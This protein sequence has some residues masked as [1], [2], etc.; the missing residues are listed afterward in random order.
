MTVV[1]SSSPFSSFVLDSSR[2]RVTVSPAGSMERSTK[3]KSGSTFLERVL[4]GL[5]SPFRRRD[6]EV[7]EF[8]RTPPGAS[9]PPPEASFEDV[10]EVL[11]LI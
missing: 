6:E 1:F 4:K 5:K 11:I 10:P 3:A 7:V 9:P 8:S 2:H